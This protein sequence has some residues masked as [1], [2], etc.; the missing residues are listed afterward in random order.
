MLDPISFD[1]KNKK[2]IYIQIA[3]IYI[4]KIE[5]GVL[6]QDT[7]LPSVRELKKQYNVSKDT[8]ER[9]YSEL[10]K[11]G[12]INSALGK[13]Y[14][15]CSINRSDKL[16]ILCILNNFSLFKQRIYYSFKNALGSKAD[17]EFQV[18]NY[19][20]FT[21]KGILEN[22]LWQFNYIVVTPIFESGSD[23][24]T[25]KSILKLIPESKLVILD[26]F[27]P[28]IPCHKAVVQD[29][30]TDITGA[31]INAESLL[32]KYQYRAVILPRNSNQLT[33]MIEDGLMKFGKET[34]QKIKS[35]H[36]VLNIKPTKGTTY[37][38]LSD[39][40]LVI[41]LLK[42][43]GT[44]LKIGVDIGIISYNESE[45]K[46]LLDITVIS[47]DFKKMG[48]TA[49]DLILNNKNELIKNP[50]RIIKRGSL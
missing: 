38:V 28:D 27:I 15:V 14:F 12:Y 11:R 39:E 37:I 23:L 20:P 17:V 2:S 42:L 16:K 40:D 6:P 19:N 49:A 25:C 22:N 31:L 41:L 8:V 46:D 9:A 34:N 4:S 48:E 32:S 10:K 33:E 43:K 24:A 26:K 35:I 1:P 36:N 5:Q 30:Y 50:F 13:G 29:F 21:L 18:Y 47:T 7:L 45:L 3:E 44:D